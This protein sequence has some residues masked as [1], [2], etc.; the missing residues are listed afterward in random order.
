MTDPIPW[1]PRNIP[2][3]GPVIDDARPCRLTRRGRARLAGQAIYNH[4]WGLGW[5]G[6]PTPRRAAPVQL[7]LYPEARR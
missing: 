2:P 7:D 5:I 6:S 4:T 1:G 3:D